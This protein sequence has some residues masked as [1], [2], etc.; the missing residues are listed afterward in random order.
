VPERL[1][2]DLS[3]RARREV[4]DRVAHDARE[5]LLAERGREPHDRDQRRQ[6]RERHLK[7]ERAR[8]AEA[9]GGPEAEDRVEEKP[10]PARAPERLDRLVALELAPGRGNEAGGRHELVEVDDTQQK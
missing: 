1:G 6:Q 3:R 5:V 2:E 4:L 9:V 10:P 8:V 7:R